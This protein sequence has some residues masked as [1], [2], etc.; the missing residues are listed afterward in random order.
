[1]FESLIQIAVQVQM[2]YYFDSFEADA[3]WFGGSVDNLM[4]SIGLAV[5][6]AFLEFIQLYFEAR[7]CKTSLINYCVVCFNGKF[8]WVPFVDNM[9]AIANQPNQ[10]AI[11]NQDLNNMES[12]HHN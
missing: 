8:G 11:S 12:Q 4:I 2:L 3:E 10:D 7:A 1:M 9:K 6:H 5:A